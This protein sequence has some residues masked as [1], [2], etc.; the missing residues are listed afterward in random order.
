MPTSDRRLSGSRAARAAV[1]RGVAFFVCWVVLMGRTAIAPADVIVGLLA[2]IAA[3]W[4]SLRLMPS[5]GNAWSVTGIVRL[6][7]RFVYQSIIAGV[8]VARRAFDPRMPLQSGEVVYPVQLRAGP[9]R[10]MFAAITSL[11]P[12]TLPIGDD[13]A[14]RMR[15]HCLDVEA[16]V[17][18]QLKVDERLVARALGAEQPA[19]SRSDQRP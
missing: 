4:A 12:G 10:S 19:T 6:S 1:L 9:P 2:T 5:D 3:A 17:V 14:G 15:Y 16:P 13:A 11:V 7:L 18:E 8:D